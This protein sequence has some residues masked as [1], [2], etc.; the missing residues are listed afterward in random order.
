MSDGDSERVE[1]A[2]EIGE[3]F[4]CSTRSVILSRHDYRF[5]SASPVA[6]VIASA[7]QTPM[8]SYTTYAPIARAYRRNLHS[9]RRVPTPPIS[10][11]LT[12][13]KRV[14]G[15]RKCVSGSKKCVTGKVFCAIPAPRVMTVQ[16]PDR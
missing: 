5:R 9:R 3:H 8:N 16:K 1:H 4:A 13:R 15:G 12:L 11:I 10:A 2:I 7:P 14:S 6:K